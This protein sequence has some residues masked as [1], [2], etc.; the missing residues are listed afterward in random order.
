MDPKHDPNEFNAF[1][2]WAAVL[3]HVKAGKR[4]WYKAPMDHRPRSIGAKVRGNGQKV[5][6]DPLSNEADPFWADKGHL[7]RFMWRPYDQNK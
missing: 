6:V 2:T 1:S 4:T 3:A 5:R 7:S